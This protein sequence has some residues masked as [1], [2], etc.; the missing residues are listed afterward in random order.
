ML[1]LRSWVRGSEWWQASVDFREAAKLRLEEA[2]VEI[3]FNQLDLYV[4]ELPAGPK[5]AKA[6]MKPSA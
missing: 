4:R 1:C 2:D 3:P 5:P 6:S